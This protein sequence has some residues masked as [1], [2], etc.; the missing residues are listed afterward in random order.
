MAM[1]HTY[2]H[3]IYIVSLEQ[4]AAITMEL[5]LTLGTNIKI[6]PRSFAEAT[7]LVV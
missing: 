2:K 5:T 4:P 6:N 1:L 3:G 7:L